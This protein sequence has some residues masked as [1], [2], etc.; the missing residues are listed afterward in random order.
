MGAL[1]QDGQA[2]ET[3]CRNITLNF[4]FANSEEKRS[5]QSET[6]KYG[7]ESQ[8]TGTRGLG[9][10]SSIYKRQTRLPVREGARQKQDLNSQTVINIWS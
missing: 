9:R 4:T 5:L 6:V 10:A 1:L 3:V 2:D 7:Q 8:W